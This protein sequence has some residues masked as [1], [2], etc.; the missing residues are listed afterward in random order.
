MCEFDKLDKTFVSDL[1][2]IY[3][4]SPSARV[5]ISDKDR[6]LMFY[7]LHRARE[8]QATNKKMFETWEVGKALK[9]LLRFFS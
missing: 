1:C 6:L 2:L 3:K 8:S 7:L 5:C 9:N 4:R